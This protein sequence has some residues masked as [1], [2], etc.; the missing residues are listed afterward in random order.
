MNKNNTSHVVLLIILII[1][2][3]FMLFYTLNKS[4]NYSYKNTENT[5][6]EN[7]NSGISGIVEPPKTN[8]VLGEKEMK[9]KLDIINR[10]NNYTVL[11]AK[12]K[13]DI[14]RDVCKEK[15]N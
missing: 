8:I 9:L 6:V 10:I 14:S 3:I 12:E 7:K 2:A 11:T 13:S 5:K 15:R 4:N 1:I